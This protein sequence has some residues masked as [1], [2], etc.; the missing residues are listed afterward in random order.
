METATEMKYQRRYPDT[1]LS[2]YIKCFWALE[3]TN[4]Q[5]IPVTIL[6]DGYFDILFLSVNGQPFQASLIG[7]AT[8]QTTFE[9]PA[10]SRTFAVSLKLPAAEYILKT[11]IGSLLDKWEYLPENYLGLAF[12]DFCNL[13]SF[14][15][16]VTVL[17][18]QLLCPK[19]D[20]RKLTLFRRVYETD[21]DIV[22]TSVAELIG[23]SS[24][25]I[26]RYFQ[27]NFGLSLKKYCSILRFRAS[28]DHLHSGQLTPLPAYFD[29]P[30]FIREVNK[31][32]GT[33][34]RHLAVNENDRF[35]QLTTL[36]D[37]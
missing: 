28:F 20:T 15:E 2:D 33:S 26:N 12:A 6:P 31:F 14:V 19:A 23:L 3:N 30:H 34:P 10:G 27:N 5:N 4:P 35:I 9:V 29:Q 11:K 8:I 22:I 37:E 13:D 24:R 17:I 21:G 32:S 36:A 1:A 16:S 25:Q 18:T 7:L